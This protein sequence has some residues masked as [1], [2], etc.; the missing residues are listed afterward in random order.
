MP[1]VPSGPIVAPEWALIHLQRS[2]WDP[3]DP[4]QLGSLNPDLQF[5]VNGEV[6]RFSSEKTLRKFMRTP[7]TWCGTVRDPV[8]G[9]VFKPCKDCPES[10]WIGG[11]Y[12]FESDSTRQVFVDDPH[13][14]AIIRTS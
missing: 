5:R 2:L 3:V 8:S 9:R 7:R 11:P 10:Y 1:R 14:Y 13:K 12:F 6:Y 4:K